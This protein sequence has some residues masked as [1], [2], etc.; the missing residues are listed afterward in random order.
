MS[1]NFQRVSWKDVSYYF[2]KLNQP[3]YNI[4]D[5]IS[6]D[7]PI[8]LVRYPYGTI[9]SDPNYYFY[10]TGSGVEPLAAKNS[11]YC[12]LIERKVQTFLK[13]KNKVIPGRIYQ[14]GDF[15][16]QNYE[17]SQFQD[18]SVRPK[19]IFYLSAGLRNIHMMP[20]TNDGDSYKKL[21]KH[22]NIDIKLSPKNIADHYDILSSIN[23]Q[24]PAKWDCTMLLFDEAWKKKIFT[25]PK[26]HKLKEFILIQSIRTN[27]CKRNA[28]Y[29]EHAINDITR[30]YKIN[31]K[32][33]SNE[34]IKN[35]L[36]TSIGEL[37]GS[38][39]SSNDEGLPASHLTD[40]FTKIYHP[41]TTPVIIEP[42]NFN[43]N[44]DSDPIYISLLASTFNLNDEKTF[45]PNVYLDEV[46]HSL[47]TYL[48][49]FKNHPFTTNTIFETLHKQISL[50][51]YSVMGD[52]RNINSADKLLDDDY[53]FN[54]IY[55]KFKDTVQYGFTKRSIF[56]KALVSV[57]PLI[58]QE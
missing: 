4:I 42:H 49:E 18:I 55:N 29:L 39:P 2:E 50:K 5:E 33:L 6:P 25:D 9:I 58:G 8:T 54:Q 46:S 12:F 24:A 30:K 1:E 32:G 11:P 14:P 41:S 45:R 7:L 28:F 38:R 31:N 44:T 34:M 47:E 21:K 56:N 27:S 20:M 10:P 52:N 16:P 3:L 36:Y 17:I 40:I 35:I 48:E 22:F 19:A 57:R 37:L 53:R 43:L 13:H 26:W 23:Q 51:F 15:F